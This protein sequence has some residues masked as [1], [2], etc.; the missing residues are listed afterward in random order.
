MNLVDK[1]VD[2]RVQL[3]KLMEYAVD[4]L[5]E[6]TLALMSFNNWPPLSKVD[7][8][9]VVSLFTFRNALNCVI[10]FRVRAVKTEKMVFN[11]RFL[12]QRRCLAASP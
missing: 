5:A 3:I 8:S 6:F 12:P 2:E 1:L 9:P 11:A 4:E 10:R 7:C